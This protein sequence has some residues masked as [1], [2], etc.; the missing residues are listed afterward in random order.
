[1]QLAYTMTFSTTELLIIVDALS[2]HP[3]GQVLHKE[4]TEVLTGETEPD[5]G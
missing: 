1:M 2:K 3:Q 5:E 4:I